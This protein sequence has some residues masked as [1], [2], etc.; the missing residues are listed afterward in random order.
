MVKKYLILCFAA[1]L[2][3]C[4]DKE[5]RKN[6]YA[7][8]EAAIDRYV[9]SLSSD[10]TVVYSDGVVRVILEEGGSEAVRSG[11][12][13]YFHYS[14]YVF[15]N[16]KGG[17]FYTNDPVVAEETGFVTDGKAFGVRFGHSA[18]VEGLKKGL[19]GVKEGEHCYIIFSARY[20]YGNQTMSTL[21]K[22][23]PLLFEMKI[24][25]IKRN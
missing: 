6:T 21:P 23:T 25:K 24:D 13:L 14:G 7:N 5:D 22:L 9:S 20:G 2:A 10:Y 19:E 1:L 8:Q 17:L 4:C 11:D 18:M 12:S 3:V 15:S 16:G